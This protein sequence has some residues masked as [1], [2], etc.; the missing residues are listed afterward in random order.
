MSFCLFFVILIILM[1]LDVFGLFF[2]INFNLWVVKGKL[3]FCSNVEINIMKN[4]ILK[5][6]FVLGKLKMSGKIVNIMGIEFFSFIYEISNVVLNENW[7][8]K[9]SGIIIK[10]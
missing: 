5:I 1:V 2:S 6:S 9:S 3:E 10:G 4:M 8:S 7:L